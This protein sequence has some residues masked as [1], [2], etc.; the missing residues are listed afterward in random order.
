MVPPANPNNAKIK[1]IFGNQGNART[2]KLPYMQLLTMI[3]FRRILSPNIVIEAN[4][5]L[6]VVF[7]K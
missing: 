1:Q 5:T 7:Q 4:K 2:A 6:V 3:L